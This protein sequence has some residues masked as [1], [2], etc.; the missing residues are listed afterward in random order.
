LLTR[1]MAWFA[2][3]YL[4]AGTLVMLNRKAEPLTQT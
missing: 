1:T 2:L 4:T 3:L